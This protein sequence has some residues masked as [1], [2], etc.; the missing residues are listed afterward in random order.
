MAKRSRK[1]AST[2]G[3]IFAVPGRALRWSARG[4]LHALPL[5]M[6]LGSVAMGALNLW[7]VAMHDKRFIVGGDTVS[8]TGAARFCKEAQAEV[9]RL[10]AVS[11][12]RSILDPWL[13]ADIKR[14]YEKSPWIKRVCSVSR[15]FPNRIAVEFVLRMPVAQVRRNGWYWMVDNEGVLLRVDASATPHPGLPEIV[16]ATH[17]LISRQP[18]Y[19]EIW[20]DQGVLDA[21]GALRAMRNSPL[22]E[23]LHVTRILVHRGSFLDSLACRRRKRPRLDLQ[24]REGILIRWGTYNTGDVPEE[25][26]SQEKIAMLRNL[27]SREFAGPGICLDVRTRVPGFSLPRQSMQP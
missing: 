17:S 1:S 9:R 12:G 11:S 26:R 21:L 14:E 23:D 16:S 8:L 25:I 3:S 22:S 13:L 7:R 27:V 6:I 2:S 5:V 24:T 15:E 20:K 10:G 4:V 18:A 19:G